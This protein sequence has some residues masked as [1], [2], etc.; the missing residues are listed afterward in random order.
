MLRKNQTNFGS[1]KIKGIVFLQI[2]AKKNIVMLILWNVRM[3]TML[4]R[5]FNSEKNIFPKKFFDLNIN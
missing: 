5:P 3:E 1:K 4:D 2:A